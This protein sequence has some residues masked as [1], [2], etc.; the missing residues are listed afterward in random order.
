MRGERDRRYNQPTDLLLHERRV[1]FEVILHH[2]A[3]PKVKIDT[4]PG[5]LGAKKHIWRTGQVER[6]LDSLGQCL[7]RALNCV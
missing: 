2:A 3:A 1:P 5:D 6:E 7:A 4:F